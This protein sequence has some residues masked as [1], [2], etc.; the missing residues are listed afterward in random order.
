MKLQKSLRVNKFSLVASKRTKCLGI[1]LMKDVQDLNTENYKAL[2]RKLNGK[3][4]MF[5]DRK[6]ATLSK[7]I[8]GFSCNPC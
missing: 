4:S 2:L 8:Y 5:M 6:M 3:T 1:T 7:F